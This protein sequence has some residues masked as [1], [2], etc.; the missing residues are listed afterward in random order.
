LKKTLD[1]WVAELYNRA[2]GE[3][4]TKDLLKGIVLLSKMID[5]VKPI[6]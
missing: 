2:T 3:V 1:P 6:L 4:E 5:K